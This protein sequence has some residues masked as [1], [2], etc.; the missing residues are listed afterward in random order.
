[1]RTVGLLREEGTLT[2]T[3]G[4]RFRV[5][6]SHSAWFPGN[7]TVNPPSE[8]GDSPRALHNDDPAVWRLVKAKLQTSLA[9][10]DLFRGG[11]DVW[12]NED[13]RRTPQSLRH[14]SV[15]GELRGCLR[16]GADKISSEGLVPV[17]NQIL[18]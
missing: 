3:K 9:L 17:L 12:R 1:M 18:L 10:V 8:V 7:N 13:C 11:T 15:K 2:I 14:S 6:T 5:A 4:Y 16:E